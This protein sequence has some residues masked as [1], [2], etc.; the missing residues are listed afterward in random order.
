MYTPDLEEGQVR[1][2]YRL[3]LSLLASGQ[4]GITLASLARTAI[5]RFLQVEESKIQNSKDRSYNFLAEP[6]KE[7]SVAESR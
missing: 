1:R 3:K 7:E 4:R 6:T 5:E 2:L